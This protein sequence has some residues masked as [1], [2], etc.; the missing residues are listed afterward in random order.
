MA[1]IQNESVM[2]QIKGMLEQLQKTDPKQ[3][4]IIMNLLQEVVKEYNS[5]RSMNIEGKL[6]DMIDGET[7]ETPKGKR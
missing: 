3:S 4:K 6:Y 2:H 5:G 7:F 1:G